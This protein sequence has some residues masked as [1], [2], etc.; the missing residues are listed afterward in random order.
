MDVISSLAAAAVAALA[1]Y[2][3]KAGEEFAKEFGK[4]AA[5]KID[6]LYQ[7]LKTRFKNEPAA[8]KALTN[9]KAKPTDM[10]AK[11]ALQN[12][13]KQQMITDPALVAMLQ[14]LLKE[15][16]ADREAASF[17][18]QVYD[19]NVGEIFNIGILQGGIRIDKRP[20]NP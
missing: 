20:G 7:A 1:P 15:I 8:K 13:L 12:Q 11:A 3:A 10:N 16:I 18:T 17:L 14:Q 4:I 9:L 5:S 19:G 6:A 2:L